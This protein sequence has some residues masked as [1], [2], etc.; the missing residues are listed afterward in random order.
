MSDWAATER[1]PAE[2]QL[3]E[4]VTLRGELHLQARV[5]YHDGAETPLEMLNRGDAFFA[6]SVSD[7]I[8]FISREQVAVVTCA[9]PQPRPW[10]TAVPQPFPLTSAYGRVPPRYRSTSVS[11]TRSMRRASA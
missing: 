2:I 8:A 5:A 4:G 7:G 6:L 1:L 9:P 11:S 10:F 3:A